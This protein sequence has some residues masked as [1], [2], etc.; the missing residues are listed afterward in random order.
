MKRREF[1]ALLGGASLVGPR[2]ALAQTPGR[3]YHLA[4][5]RPGAALTGDSPIGKILVKSLAQH[6]Y[7][8]GQNLTFEARA[9]IGMS[10]NFP[11]CFRS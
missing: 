2:A 11:H 3:I 8:L 4:T 6:G 9:A 10:R 7:V 5:I 1:L